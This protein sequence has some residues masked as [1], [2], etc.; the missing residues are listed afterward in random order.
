[1]GNACNQKAKQKNTPTHSIEVNKDP[2][3]AKKSHHK[4]GDPLPQ[5]RDC[6][7]TPIE[8]CRH[9]YKDEDKFIKIIKKNEIIDFTQYKGY[10]AIH[11]TFVMLAS[12]H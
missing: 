4:R 2:N 1:M 12:G 9:A 7:M 5:D 11:E 10:E 8:M 6:Y 3:S